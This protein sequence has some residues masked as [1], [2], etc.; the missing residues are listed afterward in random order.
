MSLETSPKVAQH[1]PRG[2][3]I[4]YVGWKRQRRK[5]GNPVTRNIFQPRLSETLRYGIQSRKSSPGPYGP[6]RRKSKNHALALRRHKSH[7]DR[8]RRDEAKGGGARGQRAQGS[9][10]FAER[11]CTRLRTEAQP[12]TRHHRALLLREHRFTRREGKR[13]EQKTYARRN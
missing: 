6:P 2:K 7:L 13:G 5:S 9:T 12:V 8:M 4:F 11:R 10:S 1:L 3:L